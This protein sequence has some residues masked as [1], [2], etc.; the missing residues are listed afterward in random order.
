MARHD[1]GS[2]PERV[3][4]VNGPGFLDGGTSRTDRGLP[5]GGPKF[6]LSPFGIFDFEPVSKSM[7]VKSLHP[8]VAVDQVR[9]ATGFEL[10]VEGTPPVTSMPT[11]DELRVL[12]Q[13]VDS[14][15]VL[16]ERRRA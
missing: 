13:N 8:G 7:R 11:A 6:V 16:R 15:G 9:K 3:D 10:L 12:R 4:F 14:T 2:F 5:E 1:R